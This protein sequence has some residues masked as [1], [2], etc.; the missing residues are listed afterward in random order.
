MPPNDS[1]TACYALL[2]GLWSA[3]SLCM[4]ALHALVWGFCYSHLG[5]PLALAAARALLF[6]V[7]VLALNGALEGVM[8]AASRCSEA[9]CAA[10]AHALLLPAHPPPGPA[11]ALDLQRVVQPQQAGQ[12]LLLYATSTQRV[13][14]SAKV[15]RL[16]HP[17]P[18]ARSPLIIPLAPSLLMY[19]HRPMRMHHAAIMPHH[20]TPPHLAP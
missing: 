4:L 16:R 10:H 3:P 13:V 14:T 6:M 15:S 1:T 18:L 5:F 17:L 8:R 7:A 12:Q 9:R 20:H 11:L 19:A 2:Q